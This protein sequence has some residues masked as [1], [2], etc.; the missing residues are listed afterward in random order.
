ME[1]I[2]RRRFLAE[3]MLGAAAAAT[4]CPTSGTAQQKTSGS[5]SNKVR[6]AIIGCGIRGKQ[7]AQELGRLSDCEIV[8]VCDPDRDRSAELAA[9]IEKQDGAAPKPVQ[10]M[11]RIFDDLS[12]DAVFIAT[13]NHWH[14][15]AAIWAM[16]AGQDVYVEKPVSHNITEGRRIVE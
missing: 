2:T 12:V 8:Y 4:A 10:D 15:L 1:K 13:P 6:V 7:H 9:S 14:A 16:Q 11:R 3:A 5:P